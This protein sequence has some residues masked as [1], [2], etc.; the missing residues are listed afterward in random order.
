MVGWKRKWL[1]VTWRTEGP[2][3][4]ADRPVASWEALRGQ[5]REGA[6]IKT[7]G[8]I[9]V[10]SPRRVRCYPEPSDVCYLPSRAPPP[11][12]DSWRELQTPGEG[13]GCPHSQPFSLERSGTPATRTL[14]LPLPLWWR[15][16]PPLPAG[17]R[18]GRGLGPRA[19]VWSRSGQARS[20]RDSAD[21]AS[22]PARTSSSERERYNARAEQRRAP[23]GSSSHIS[24]EYNG[25][26]S[27]E[28][29]LEPDPRCAAL[30][31]AAGGDLSL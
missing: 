9:S 11:P 22:P 10:R 24:R 3:I 18:G 19:T 20:P 7:K 17:P 6:S 21:P 1:Q 2:W 23:A 16:V 31:S 29:L 30:V 26:V 12:S 25:E 14:C 8:F 13:S 15:P 5:S 4:S 28:L 27:G